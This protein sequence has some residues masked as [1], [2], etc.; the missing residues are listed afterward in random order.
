M[1]TADNLP[2]KSLGLGGDGDEIAAISEVERRFG[3]R[4]DYSDA[5][6]WKTAGDVFAALQQALS[7]EQAE[8][9]E[10]WPLFAEAISGETGVDPTKVTADTLLLGKGRFDWR[11]LVVV[12]CL[13]AA[14]FALIQLW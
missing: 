8:A 5:R 13:I 11:V 4:L 10:T 9:V 14:G 7:S 3:V 6:H 12:G 1:A 2:P